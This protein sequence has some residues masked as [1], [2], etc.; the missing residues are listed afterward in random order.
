VTTFLAIVALMTLAAVAVVA[1]PLL[2]DREHRSPVAALVAAL[3]IPGAVLF[4]YATESSYPWQSATAGPAE[5]AAIEALRERTQ[6]SPAD[7]QAWTA[8]GEALIAEQRFAEARDAFAQALR[9]GDPEDDALRLSYA[10]STILADRNA[11]A[12]EAAEIIEAVLAGDP[13]NAKALWYGGM[14]ALGR[15]DTAV[16]RDRWTRLLALEPPPQ[17]RA[18]IAEQVARLDGD[19]AA[20]PADAGARIALRVSVDPALAPRIQ[21][22]ATLFLFARAGEGGGPPL[23]VARRD[24]GALPIDTELS[25]ADSMVPGR[26]LSGAGEVR[27]TA[28]VANDGEALAAP[29]DVY[30]EAVWRPGQGLVEIR[31]DRLVE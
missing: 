19:T 28:R 29:G 21:P 3:A 1:V 13:V 7:A 12:G 15:G 26:S 30:G 6:A 10:E 24:A 11:L 22:G 27:V 20:A 31:M 18:I 5:S 17:V 9:T 2:G 14:V 8:L 4:L 25:D 23:A 16:A